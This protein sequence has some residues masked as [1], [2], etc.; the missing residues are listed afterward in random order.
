M[1]FVAREAGPFGLGSDVRDL[2]FGGAA[3]MYA[4]ENFVMI[5]SFGKNRV[6]ADGVDT[7]G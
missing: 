2:K 1:S 7:G 6:N 4:F 3:F 5:G